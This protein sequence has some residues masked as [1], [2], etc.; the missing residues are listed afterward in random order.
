[1]AFAENDGGRAAAG[2][3]GKTGDCGVR[4]A[5][6][7]TGIPYG[8]TYK[9]LFARQKAYHASSRKACVKKAEAR[10]IKASP[11]GGI[12]K[13]V[14]NPFLIEQGATYISLAGIGKPVVRVK[15]VAEMYPDKRLVMQ[16]ARHFSAMVNGVNL[17]TWEQHPEKRVYS[18]W[19]F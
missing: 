4:A 15:N 16:L 18:V 1:M 8:Q 11:R 2:F 10:T 13:D 6:L 12:W 9:E 17:D 5:A 14:I 19:V 3:K 7:A